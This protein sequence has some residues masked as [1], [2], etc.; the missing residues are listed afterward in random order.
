M[1]PLGDNKSLCYHVRTE[2]VSN[3][4]RNALGL[5]GFGSFNPQSYPD[6]IG[7]Y[8]AEGSSGPPRK[9]RGLCHMTQPLYCFETVFRIGKNIS[10]SKTKGKQFWTVKKISEIQNVITLF[11]IKFRGAVRG[12]FEF[13]DQNAVLIIGPP[14]GTDLSTNEAS[15]TV[16]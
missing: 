16:W 3:A 8:V 5:T 13:L 2:V 1:E 10:D 14:G 9:K 4:A 12:R 6:M 7:L 15:P 11:Q